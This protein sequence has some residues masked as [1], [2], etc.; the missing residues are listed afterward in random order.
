MRLRA[1]PEHVAKHYLLVE[2]GDT[3]QFT[4][5]PF[6]LVFVELGVHRLKKRSHE[7][8]LPCWADNGALEPEITDYING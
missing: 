7:R 2:D 6:G 5:V 8:Q 4:T 1:H 3:A